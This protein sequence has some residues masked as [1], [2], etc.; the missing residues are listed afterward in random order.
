MQVFKTCLKLF[1]SLM[2]FYI[3]CWIY[4]K[5]WVETTDESYF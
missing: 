3:N 5:L 2:T 4:R 1:F